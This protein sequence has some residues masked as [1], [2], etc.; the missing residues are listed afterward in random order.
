ML[1]FSTCKAFAEW[2]DYLV[3][4]VGGSRDW[5][6]VA[7]LC[8]FQLWLIDELLNRGCM[9]YVS[10]FMNAVKPQLQVYSCEKL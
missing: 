9:Y 8:V 10:N 2:W 4:T 7:L 1:V 3:F 6:L 5:G